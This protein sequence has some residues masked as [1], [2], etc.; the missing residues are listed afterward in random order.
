[1]YNSSRCG[2]IAAAE[3]EEMYRTLYKIACT[4][5]DVANEV[6]RSIGGFAQGIASIAYAM[7][8]GKP[9]QFKRLDGWGGGCVAGSM[10]NIKT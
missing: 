2:S 6:T 10:V 8:D 9:R 7:L 1:M 4:S 5:N 3:T